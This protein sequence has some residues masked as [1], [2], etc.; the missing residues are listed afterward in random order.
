MNEG[1]EDFY[2]KAVTRLGDTRKIITNCDIYAE[3]GHLLLAEGFRISDKLYELIVNHKLSPPIEEC[4]VMEGMANKKIILDDINKLVRKSKKL[5]QMTEIIKSRYSVGSIISD[6]AL[7]AELAFKLTIAREEFQDI[8]QR[9]LSGLIVS[10]YLAYC[11]GMHRHR[12]VWVAMAG[13]FRNIGLLHINPQWLV[14]SYTMTVEERQHL[15]A[16]PLTG[17]LFLQAFSGMPG[18]VVEAVLEHHECND[19]SGY[20]R[21]IS[22][23]KISRYGQ[24]LAVAE[25]S[26]KSFELDSSRHELRKLEVMLKLSTKRYEKDLIGY[27]LPFTTNDETIPI[28]DIPDLHGGLEKTRLLSKILNDFNRHGNV[29]LVQSDEMYRYTRKKIQRLAREFYATG[30]DLNDLENLIKHFEDDPGAISEYLI[31]LD[32]VFWQLKSLVLSIF[33]VWKDT[34]EEKGYRT[35]KVEY[36]W[37]KQMKRSLGIEL[38]ADQNRS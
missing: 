31:L 30:I 4:L 26:C 37:L 22:G 21:G 19:G 16:H 28:P 35:G 33:R 32:E 25:I 3:D 2:L 36:A 34:L 6:L 15:Y 29:Y 13:L 23:D 17:H 12:C 8:Y 1:I 10:L 7:L 38:V 24:I 20:P 18:D 11:D 5:E 27:I 14:A 9:S